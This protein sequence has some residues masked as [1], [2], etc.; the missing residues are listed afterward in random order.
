MTP[1]PI[2]I[3]KDADLAEA[4]EIMVKHGINGLP[5]TESS[6]NVEKPI[7]IISKFDII[8]VLTRQE[9]EDELAE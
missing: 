1:N 2:T 8:K 9:G 7:G 4:A 6:I 3:E 5:V